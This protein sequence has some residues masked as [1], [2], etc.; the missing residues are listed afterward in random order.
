MAQAVA[1]ALGRPALLDHMRVHARREYEERYTAARNYQI[2][3]SIYAAAGLGR[4]AG[5]SYH[6]AA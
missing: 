6:A 2:L 3:M 5:D 1:Y 4:S